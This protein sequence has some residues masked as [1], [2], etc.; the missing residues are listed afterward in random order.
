MTMDGADM[1]AYPTGGFVGVT[2]AC[3]IFM[4]RDARDA[5]E[6]RCDVRV[7]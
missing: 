1:Q 4:D 5:D 3:S 2:D 6:V 7:Q